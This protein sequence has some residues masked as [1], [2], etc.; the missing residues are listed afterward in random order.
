DHRGGGRVPTGNCGRGVCGAG[1]V[2]RDLDLGAPPEAGGSMTR[3]AEILPR[4]LGRVRRRLALD[5]ALRW[6]ARAAAVIGW[7]TL[8]LALATMAVPLRFPIRAVAVVEAAGL[9]AGLALLACL[10]PGLLAAARLTDRRLGL[11]D[12]LS[13]AVELLA[14]PPAAAVPGGMARLQMA[15]AVEVA[16]GIAPRAAAP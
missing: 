4:L 6:V 1:G 5:R 7:S 15:D 9:L 10:R 3:D 14:A 16:Q 8:G 2:L 12:R 13:T 11:A